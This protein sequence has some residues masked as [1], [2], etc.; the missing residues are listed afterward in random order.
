MRTSK[1]PV[2]EPETEDQNQNDALEQEY[3]KIF[4]QFKIM[5]D[6]LL[7]SHME[8]LEISPEQFE[9]ACL[10]AKENLGARLHTVLFEQLWAAFN[11]RIFKRMMIQRN[12]DLQLQALELLGQK[13]NVSSETLSASSLS[14]E[15]VVCDEEFEMMRELFK[16]SLS[17]NLG[18]QAS[19]QTTKETATKQIANEVTVPKSS[20]SSA[21]SMPVSAGVKEESADKKPTETSESKSRPISGRRRSS[22]S[23]FIDNILHNNHSDNNNNTPATG[24]S[25]PAELDSEQK[26]QMLI[27]NLDGEISKEELEKRQAYLRQQ[28]DKL[29]ELKR[30]ERSKQIAKV[31][32][33]Q[34]SSG[35]P[36]SARALRASTKKAS[37]ITEDEED[38]SKEKAEENKENKSNN[39]YRRILHA[40]LNADL[41]GGYV[42]DDLIRPSTSQS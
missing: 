12:I 42:T 2:F 35:R 13:L 19:E 25:N 30:K 41:I 20:P 3:S 15:S 31:G 22:Q 10:A 16:R 38:E 32:D 4:N 34:Q 1:P 17:S 9:S 39:G 36:K 28:R 18:G 11:Y 23:A 14:P 21:I 26:M 8:D 6:T 24:D 40:R 29:I 5:V 27:G 7:A 33:E 37:F